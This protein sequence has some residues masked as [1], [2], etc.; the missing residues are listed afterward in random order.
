MITDTFAAGLLQFLGAPLTKDNVNFLRAWSKKENTKATNN[1]LATTWDMR[2][3]GATLFN[4]AGVQNYPSE[5]V[6]IAAT[7]QTIK[8]RS[9]NPILNAL[10]QGTNHPLNL[11]TDAENSF[12]L[13]SG[14]GKNYRKDVLSIFDTVKTYPVI[15][16]HPA[17]DNAAN[18]PKSGTGE[19]ILLLLLGAITLGL[20]I[21]AAA[22]FYDI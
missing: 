11:G 7:G 2:S 21:Y 15:I 17:G 4:S 12:K 22:R 13:W 20:I 8:Q 19:N 9:M 16:P 1:P 18:D 5:S 6:G 10:L 3:K 14:E